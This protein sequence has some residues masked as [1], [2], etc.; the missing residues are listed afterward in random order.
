M[1]KCIYWLKIGA[2]IIITKCFF[3]GI[4]PLIREFCFNIRILVRIESIKL[5]EFISIFYLIFYFL[6]PKFQ[7]IIY[8]DFPPSFSNSFWISKH[9]QISY[10]CRC[11][12]SMKLHVV[13]AVTDVVSLD[14]VLCLIKKSM[15][16]ILLSH[17]ILQPFSYGYYFSLDPTPSP[18]N[19]FKQFPVSPRHN[20]ISFL[21]PERSS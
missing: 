20:L 3:G 18:L 8:L 11:V 5:S 4:T 13:Q 14:S 1:R 19:Y 7:T 17:E 21:I 16:Y 9:F 6:G 15:N 12:S 10:F 2:I